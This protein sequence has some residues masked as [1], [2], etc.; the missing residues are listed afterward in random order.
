MDGDR[1]DGT[2]HRHPAT[3]DYPKGF[4]EA[5]WWPVVAATGA[6][7]AYVG[8]GV[9]LSGDRVTGLAVVAA[10]AGTL[11]AAL[12]GWF[13]HGFVVGDGSPSSGTLYRGGRWA[14]FAEAATVIS[15]VA[16]AGYL[17]ATGPPVDHVT[18]PG[19]PTAMTLAGTAL[20]AASALTCLWARRGMRAGDGDALR[21]G[22]AGTA[23]LGAL[24]LVG[25][26]L[27]YRELVAAGFTPADGG[28]AAAVFA[29][30]VVHAVHVAVGVGG[31][32]AAFLLA[33]RG[34]YLEDRPAGS[35]GASSR[36][37]SSRRAASHA[38]E[39]RAPGL[40]ALATYW[41]T[42]GALWVLA[43]VVVG[44]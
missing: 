17:R 12:G 31:F 39:R 15:V 1:G 21:R 42:M 18:P 36:G 28:Y 16:A 20:L 2:D 23:L 44:G 29:V 22:L 6:A 33:R 9:A 8:V 3:A 25:Q 19:V 4:G 35:R 34:Y 14:V 27:E 5:S 41:W 43:V 40:R 7:A 30:S 13:Y 11:L 10:A 26:W 37:S 38:P 24:F 32:A